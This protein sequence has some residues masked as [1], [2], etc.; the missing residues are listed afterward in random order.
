MCQYL[1][2]PNKGGGALF[3]SMDEE[4]HTTYSTEQPLYGND[5]RS[6]FYDDTDTGDFGW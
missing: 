6:Q 2:E 3:A 1:V 4:E 5:F